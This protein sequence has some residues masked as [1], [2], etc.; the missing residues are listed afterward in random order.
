MKKIALILC[1][2]LLVSAQAFAH[3][4]SD[5]K[6][7]FDNRTKTLTADIKHAVGNPL[8]HY[9]KKVDIELNGK[10]IQTLNF[11]RQET[12]AGQTLKLVIPEAQA[13]DFLSVEG[14][15]SL[16]GKLKKQIR[17]K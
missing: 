9:I 10:E 13:A 11:N 17:I 12:S 5:I 14:Y 6:I 4:P 16:S 7:K 8:N 15:C 3:P 1:G 2:L